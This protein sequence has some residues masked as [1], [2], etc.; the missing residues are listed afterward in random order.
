MDGSQFGSYNKS[1]EWTLYDARTVGEVIIQALVIGI[2]II[3]AVV[4]N[5]LILVAFY[6]DK[7]LQTITNAFVVNLAC[8]DL[9]L[10][11]I[12]MPFT[13]ASSVTYN[14][15]FGKAWCNVNGMANSLFCITSI[16]T[17]AAVS[18]DRYIAISFPLQYPSWMTRKTATVTIFYIWFHA[19]LFALLPVV[20]W[21]KYTFIVSE[22]ICTVHWSHDAAF[23]IFLLTVC[24]FVPLG[25]L[26]FTYFSIYQTAR[27]HSR[28]VT[29]RPGKLMSLEKNGDGRLGPSNISH[30]E[31]SSTGEWYG[32]KISLNSNNSINIMNQTDSLE[33]VYHN[34][35]NCFATQT[36]NKVTFTTGNDGRTDNNH[37]RVNHEGRTSTTTVSE[38]STSQEFANGE[39]TTNG[40]Q[41]SSNKFYDFENGKIKLDSIPSF[42]VGN[43]TL[44]THQDEGQNTRTG[45]GKK[46]TQGKTCLILETNSTSNE[47]CN[48][49]NHVLCKLMTSNGGL[50]SKTSHQDLG[51]NGDHSLVNNSRQSALPNPI[52][53]ARSSINVLSESS[54]RFLRK[55]WNKIERANNIRMRRDT[56]AAKTLFFV[57]GTFI[58][59]WAPHFIGI[60]CLLTPGCRWPDRFYAITTWLAMLNSACNPIIYGVMSRQFRKRFKQ[61]LK[62]QK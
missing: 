12:G 1:T 51:V 53:K 14:W 4:G 37:S 21:S 46:L 40:F 49:N 13:M 48:E 30:V 22:S 11:L 44:Q 23:T 43:S 57:M 59:C 24:F 7:T 39:S 36:V 56:K 27:K 19:F 25:V 15:I 26:L 31:N 55:H 16:L 58:L 8:A 42:K 32:S 6:I 33:S 28:R 45:Y 38:F 50:N 52:L 35:I 18:V 61:I 20:A 9:A 17:L 5:L 47:T 54:N 62:C 10:S 2:I 60:F 3:C 34:T 41:K 29:P